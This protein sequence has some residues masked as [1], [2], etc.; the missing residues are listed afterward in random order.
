MTLKLVP[1]IYEVYGFGPN[2]NTAEA[3]QARFTAT[4][5]FI[6]GRCDGG[7]NRHQTKIKLGTSPLRDNFEPSLDSVVPGICSIQHGGTIW[8]VC[9]RRLLGFGGSPDSAQVNYALQEHEK[10]ALLASGLPAGIELGVWAE[11]YLNYGDDE[12]TINYHFD[13]VISELHRN[14]SFHEMIG[15]YGAIEDAEHIDLVAAARKGQYIQ[16]R[17]DQNAPISVLP[18]L[19]HPYIIEVMTASTSGSDTSAGT[20]IASSFSDAILG[21]S[22]SCPGIN[23]RQVWGRMATQLFAKSALADAWGG[24]TVWVVQDELLKNIAL[25]TKLGMMTDGN[26]GGV[27][28]I[29]FVGLSYRKEDEDGCSMQVVGLHEKRSGLDFAGSGK[30]V[31]IL[32]P[33]VYP[34]KKE[35]LKSVLR[36]KL[37]ALIVL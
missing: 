11:V 35:L 29:S 26:I 10:E 15:S 33:K 28:K 8:V 23:K 19:Q 20:D 24:K 1:S 4:C 25:T 31:D 13:F 6:G 27:D 7:G 14:A 2:D 12:T 32:L 16:G 3:Q 9:P 17:L 30:C 37:S 34:C 5:P 18:N 22:H 21:R 36:R